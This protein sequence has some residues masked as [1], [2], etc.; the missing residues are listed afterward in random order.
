MIANY[1]LLA[2]RN[3]LRQR[4]YSLVNIFGLAV[5]LAAAICIL[6]YVNDELTFDRMHPN[7][8]SLYRLGL[9]YQLSSGETGS[10]GYAPA[11]W[12]NYIQSNYEEVSAITSFIRRGMPT[13]VH[14]IPTDKIVLAED[15]DC[16]TWAE[17]S[18]T[19]ILSIPIVRGAQT[20]PLKEIHSI[21]LTEQAAY[22]I[23][24][25]EDPIGKILT[26]S[27]MFATNN[28][29]V[30]LMV[31]AVMKD[32]PSNT[33]LAPKFMANILALSPFNENME[34]Q[35][36]TFM[37][38][39]GNAFYSESFFVCKDEKK[40][41]AIMDDLQKRANEIDLGP[42]IEIKLTPMVR[43]ITDVHFDKGVDWAQRKSVD[44]K[45]IYVFVTI[46]FLILVVA[47]INY[48]NL[49][50]ARSATRA[51]EIGLRKTFGGIRPQLFFQFMMESFVLVLLSSMLAVLLIVL[52]MP[53]FN[54]L[55][56]KTFSYTHIFNTEMLLIMG[57]VILIVTLLAGGYPA[58]FVSGFQPAV[59]LKGKFSFR[60]GSNVFRQALT[61]VQFGVA[62]ILLSGT[63]IVVNQMDL[64]RYSK[65]N[66][67]GNQ[68]V[69]IRYGGFSASPAGRQGS[70]TDAQYQSYKNLILQDPQIEDVTLANHLPRQ[71]NFPTQDMQVEFPDLSDQKFEWFQLN[72]DFNFPQTF[73]LKIIAGRTFDLENVADSSA[74]LLNE[75]A[76]RSL[77][78]TPEDIIGKEV[79][80]PRIAPSFSPP[81]ATQQPVHGTVIGV[82]QD[83]PFRSVNFKI[84]PLVIA[85]KPHGNDRIIYVRMP[86]ENMAQKMGELEKKWKQVFPDYGFHYWFIDDEFGRMYANEVRVAALVEKFSW[87]AILVACVGLYGLASFMAEQRTK[88]IGIRKTLGA[89][90]GQI[91]LLLLTVFGK[92]LLI[93]SIVGVPVAYF[94]TRN[95]LENFVYRTP[96][97]VTVFG[98]ALVVIAVITLITV[99]YETLKAA[100]ANPVK[101]IRHEG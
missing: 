34:N 20:S 91:L 26:V 27:N 88:E 51:R 28:Q 79:V 54:A 86:V 101:A 2:V 74:V 19:D 38:A 53:Q 65:L 30:D 66:E 36:N 40:I 57:G 3:L 1:T 22:E 70:A 96:L 49:A 92:L 80:R 48:I 45:Y 5:G 7:A 29:K 90:N 12:D 4:G 13:S 93:A 87:L 83:F 72:G 99:G 97:S 18:I 15:D 10:G 85:P 61:T 100:I 16:F 9:S 44:I 39:G 35:L 60:K 17:P 55:T 71:D 94:L 21:M 73:N 75:S 43:R 82:V 68:I 8:E 24:G 98:G 78:T 58:L 14:H 76:V 32:F 6:L 52:L 95:W 63:F 50:T 23:F 81:D 56:H 59:V 33:H 25:E 31:T 67:A 47:C 42:E 37:G 46:A 69:S 84:D 41:E 64:M 77:N 62:V 89:S 11:G